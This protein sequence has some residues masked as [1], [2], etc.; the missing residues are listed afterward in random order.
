[1]NLIL[2]EPKDFFSMNRARI[3]GRRFNH[4]RDVLR[5]TIGDRL[6]VGL[7]DGLMGEGEVVALGETS[8]ELETRLDQEPPSP[9][10]IDLF[11]ALPRPKFVP[12]VIQAAVSLGIKRIYLFNSFRVE[13]VYWSCEQLTPAELR[14]SCLLGLEQ[15][16]DTRLPEIHLRRLFK[17]FVEDELGALTQGARALVA[18]PGAETICPRGP[19]AEM[20]TA[21]VVGPE[22]GLIPYEIDRLQAVGFTPVRTLDRIL[23]VETALVSLVGRLT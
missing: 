21:L 17:P 10:A 3:D 5:V 11:M 22:G 15:A 18:H 6:R 1:M 20:R 4:A 7:V 23:K 16:R 19:D 14:Q 12:R 13:K 9:L 8:L 2:L